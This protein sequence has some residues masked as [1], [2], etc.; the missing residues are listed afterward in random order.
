M[1]LGSHECDRVNY[2]RHCRQKF[3]LLS[4]NARENDYDFFSEGRKIYAILLCEKPFSWIFEFDQSLICSLA[5][6]PPPN[7]LTQYCITTVQ[8]S[9]N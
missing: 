1:S 4:E 7:N 8:Q 6:L 2:A 5:I 3:R 9:W